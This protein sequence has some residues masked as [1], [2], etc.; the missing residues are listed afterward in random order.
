MLAVVYL[1]FNEGYIATSGDPLIREELAGEAVRLGRLLAGLMPDEPEAPGLLALLLLSDARR[2]ART[3]PGAPVR[4]AEQ[5]RAV[6]D[7]GRIAEGQALVR[8]LPA[9][10]TR[11]RTSSRRR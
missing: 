1:V 4:L 8:R 7:G 3:P 10:G 6:W 9:R 11:A 5:D 2:A